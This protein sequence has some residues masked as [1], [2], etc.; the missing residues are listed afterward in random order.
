MKFLLSILVLA[1]LSISN[2]L[3]AQNTQNIIVTVT[4][5]TSENGKI[6]FALFDKENFMKTPLKREIGTIKN[7]K[8]TIIFKEIPVG[9]YAITCY[10]DKNDNG[11][12]DFASNGMPLED[13]GASNNVFNFGPPSYEDAKFTVS[14]KKI[15]IAIRF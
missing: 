3:T 10:H 8:S 6:S 15:S 2:S 7:G 1:I 5:P 11:K 13:Y 14:D 12:M 4:N 9:E